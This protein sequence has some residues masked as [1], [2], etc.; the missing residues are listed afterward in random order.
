VASLAA[1]FNANQLQRPPGMSNYSYGLF[2]MRRRYQYYSS[3]YDMDATTM[4]TS[5]LERGFIELTGTDLPR[6]DQPRTYMAI[7]DR[8]PE[9]SFGLE[10]VNEEASLHVIVG[11]W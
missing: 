9:M 1:T 4:H 6:L 2:G 8:S 11:S 5:M 7:V 10:K 3:G